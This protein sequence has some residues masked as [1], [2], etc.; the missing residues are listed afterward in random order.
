MAGWRSAMDT[1]RDRSRLFDAHIENASTF[2]TLGF[3]AGRW[4]RSMARMLYATLGAGFLGSGA[5]ERS[6]GGA[7]PRVLTALIAAAQQAI[8]KSRALIAKID[9]LLTKRR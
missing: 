9:E 2:L 1:A 3:G 4:S 7:T 6:S 8:E 5:G